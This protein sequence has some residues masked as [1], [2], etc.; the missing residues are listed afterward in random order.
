MKPLRSSYP[1]SHLCNP[2]FPYVSAAATNVAETIRR[3]RER[4]QRAAVVEGWPEVSIG[5][6]KPVAQSWAQTV[7]V[8]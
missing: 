3:A 6:W 2:A 8:D 4:Q 5:E 7:R 1:S